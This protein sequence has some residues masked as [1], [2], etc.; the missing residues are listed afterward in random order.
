MVF[1]VAV[2]TKIQLVI[3][4]VNRRI[5]YVISTHLA[6]DVCAL[7]NWWILYYTNAAIHLVLQHSVFVVVHRVKMLVNS[8]RLLPFGRLEIH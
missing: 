4:A 6:L 7:A 8:V 5:F 1:F 3:F 2:C